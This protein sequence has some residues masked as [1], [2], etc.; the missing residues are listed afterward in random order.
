MVWHEAER[1]R[2]ALGTTGFTRVCARVFLWVVQLH[3]SVS[4][5]RACAGPRWL[6]GLS[7]LPVLSTPLGD[8][9]RLLSSARA[10][11][12]KIDSYVHAHK[13]VVLVG[14]DNV[15]RRNKNG[16]RRCELRCQ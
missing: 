8:A 10:R 7:T 11:A 14:G 15:G 3:R 2:E 1:D 4:C 13:S 5:G 9:H 6:H 16:G 12:W